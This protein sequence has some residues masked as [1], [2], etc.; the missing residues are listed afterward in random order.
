MTQQKQWE[1][2]RYIQMRSEYKQI[3]CYKIHLNIKITKVNSM[4][5]KYYEY[6]IVNMIHIDIH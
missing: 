5:T 4:L 3:T 6:N 1:N 2:M